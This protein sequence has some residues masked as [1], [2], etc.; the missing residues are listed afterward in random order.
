MLLIPGVLFNIFQAFLTS[1]FSE[2][3]QVLHSTM[4]H[5]R[6]SCGFGRTFRSKR[7]AF[8]LFFASFRCSFQ[9]FYCPAGICMKSIPCPILG[10]I[11]RNQISTWL[12]AICVPEF[13]SKTSDS[14]IHFQIV[15]APKSTIIKNQN[16]YLL[17]SCI[18]VIISLW[19]I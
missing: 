13:C 3:L 9:L 11:Y 7:Q 14:M 2:F 4:P 6:L 17:F 1:S 19:S 10:I 18:I 12:F 5:T 8:S 16:I 15:D